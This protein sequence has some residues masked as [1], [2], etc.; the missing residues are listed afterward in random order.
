MY[1]I[2]NSTNQGNPSNSNQ[3]DKYL[4]AKWRDGVQLTYGGSG[5]GG[6]S[7]CNYAFPWDT[8]SNNPQTWMQTGTANDLRFIPSTNLGELSPN[9]SI[10]FTMAYTVSFGDSGAISSVYKLKQDADFIK[11]FYSQNE[12]NNCSQTSSPLSLN[13]KNEKNY[14]EIFPNPNNG[15][16]QIMYSDG[17]EF[18]SLIEVFSIDGKKIFENKITSN[19]QSFVIEYSGVYL[20]KATDKDNFIQLKKLVVK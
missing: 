1:Y 16:F 13:N 15:K 2:N 18:L 12:L 4:S 9:Q 17:N 3:I 5:Y 11:E 19:K 8:D 10:C 14:W 20:I 7:N 6:S